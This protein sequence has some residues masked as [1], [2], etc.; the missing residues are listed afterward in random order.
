M[1]G[2]GA[3]KL[4]IRFIARGQNLQAE[5]VNVT[6]T[7]VT[8]AARQQRNQKAPHC[9]RASSAAPIRRQL[10]CST[11]ASARPGA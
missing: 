4:E 9:E 1:K 7:R 8:P 6:A 11:L 10:T 2:C 3:I 5:G